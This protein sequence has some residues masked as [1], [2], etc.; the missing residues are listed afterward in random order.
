MWYYEVLADLHK[1]H[2]SIPQIDII[3]FKDKRKA[4]ET[5]GKGCQQRKQSN[6]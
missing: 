4:T 6:M 2:Q 1:G 3:E 5:G